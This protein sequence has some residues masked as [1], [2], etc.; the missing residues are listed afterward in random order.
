M[1]I[2]TPPAVTG[3]Q[4][5]Y[6]RVS[7]SHQSLDQQMVALTAAGGDCHALARFAG[8]LD[9]GLPA[10]RVVKPTNYHEVSVD[11]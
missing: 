3:P 5:S 8:K 7:T 1:V 10:R 6:A 11:W 4:L 9:S 2:D